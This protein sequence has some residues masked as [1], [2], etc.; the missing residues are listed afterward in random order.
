MRLGRGRTRA[1]CSPSNANLK[2]RWL[3]SPLYALFPASVIRAYSCPK[4]IGTYGPGIYDVLTTLPHELPPN[5]SIYRVNTGAP[6]PTGADA[7]IM[8]EDTKVHSTSTDAVGQ[9]EEKQVETLAK[10][11]RG[12]NVRQPGSDAQKGDL[13][14]EKGTVL[15]GAGG[16]VGTLAFVGRTEVSVWWAWLMRCF[17]DRITG[18]G[19]SKACSRHTQHWKR[20][21]R[22]S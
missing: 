14:L 17:T 10:V 21:A 13:V 7:V 9:T 8:V 22:P 6:I 5:N 12:E 3:R 20:T 2:R 16:E 11:D 19:L 18:Q 1:R 4:R 15:L